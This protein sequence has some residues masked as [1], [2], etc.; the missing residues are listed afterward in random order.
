MTAGAGPARTESAS[1]SV[2]SRVP[3]SG[4]ERRDTSVSASC[5]RARETAYHVSV[6]APQAATTPAA[7][8]SPRDRRASASDAIAMIQKAT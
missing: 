8:T 4:V 1:C 6:V 5:T 3:G 2:S 7:A